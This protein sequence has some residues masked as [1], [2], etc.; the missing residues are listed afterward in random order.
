MPALAAAARLMRRGLTFALDLALPRTCA[1]CRHPLAE[2]G[3]RLCDECAAGLALSVDG[4]YCR[5][6]GLDVG[7][8]LLQDR[9]CTECRRHPRPL[10][11]RIVRVGRHRGTLRRLVLAF[12]REPFH[13]DLLGGMLA[14]AFERE[15]SDHS[16]E[17]VVPV[18]TPWE[19]RWTRGYQPTEL[20]ARHVARHAGVPW[21]SI[22]RM[23]RVVRPQT[24]LSAAE[25]ERNIRGAFRC[26]SRWTGPMARRQV[27]GRV[28]CLVD[29]VSTTGATLREAAGVLR[30]AGAKQVVAAVVTR[31]A[32]HPGAGPA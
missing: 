13:D 23:A 3:V 14:M 24:G 18:P 20:L 7:P 32:L 17:L 31:A 1:A 8:H 15:L 12:K 21:R 10:V 11:A 4:N 30:D 26:G 19:R 6:C 5:Q 9:R 29:D 2:P 28:V 22:L 16:V 27:R 25:R